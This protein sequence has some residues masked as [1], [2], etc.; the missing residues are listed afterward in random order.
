MTTTTVPVP[1]PITLRIQDFELSGL[2]AIG[3]EQRPRGTVLALHGGGARAAYWDNPL[4][5]DGSLLRLGATL[6]WTVFAPDR[7]GYG[8]SAGLDRA[9]Q[10]VDAQ[11]ALLSE[12]L[13]RLD[14]PLGDGVVIVGHSLGAIVGLRMA[15][16]PPRGDLIG[17]AAA[18]FPLLYTEEQIAGMALLDVEGPYARRPAGAPSQMTADDWF[19]PEGTWN[20]ELRSLSRQLLARVPAAEFLAA[21]DA[22]A[23]TAEIAAQVRLPVHWTVSEHEATA[24]EPDTILAQAARIFP[25]AAVLEL[26]KQRDSGHNISLHH[27][28]R[29]YHLR[30]MAFAEECRL[31]AMP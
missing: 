23:Q 20:A 30:V 3:D 13:D 11:P 12:A 17:Y 7:P 24:A 6:G 5:P 19:G 1:Q 15:A 8:A 27:A 18:G 2:L 9:W 29:A 22:P 21:R 31:R 4:D 28:A 10:G 14:V 26:H 25:A 16:R